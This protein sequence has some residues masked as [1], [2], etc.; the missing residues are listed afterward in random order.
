MDQILVPNNPLCEFDEADCRVL[1]W[2]F[3]NYNYDNAPDMIMVYFSSTL[4]IEGATYVTAVHNACRMKQLEKGCYM[5]RLD[6]RHQRRSVEMLKVEDG[7][8]WVAEP[9]R[10]SYAFRADGKLISSA[11]RIKSRRIAIIL[12]AIVG[13]QATFTNMIQSL[14]RYARVFE[15]Y[16]GVRFVGGRVIYIVEDVTS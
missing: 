3:H 2:S 11:R 10:T 13:S 4:N 16:Y 14:L 1:P 15:E 6:D 5:V 7:V 12:T 9:L 8:K